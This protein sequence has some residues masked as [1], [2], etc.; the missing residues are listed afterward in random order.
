MKQTVQ[1]DVSKVSKN[2]EDECSRPAQQKTCASGGHL[3]QLAAMV[4]GS[5]RVQASA[6]MKED[7]QGSARVQSLQQL[8][9]QIQPGA[10][11]QLRQE[12]SSGGNTLEHQSSLTTA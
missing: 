12:N 11:A 1:P 8:A 5:P 4:N 9:E 10:P 2:D 3:A 6:Q 7:I